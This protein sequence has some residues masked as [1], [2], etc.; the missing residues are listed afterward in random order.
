MHFELARSRVVKMDPLTS[1]DPS[2]SV[3]P[4]RRYDKEDVLVTLPGEMTIFDIKWLAVWNVDEKQ[5]YGWAIIPDGLN[6]PPSLVEIIVSCGYCRRRG[7][8][9]GKEGR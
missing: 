3:N 9:E 2:P 7:E 6:I 1:F 5:G 4:L 8:S